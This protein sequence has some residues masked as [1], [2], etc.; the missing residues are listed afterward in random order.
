[1]WVVGCT[2]SV[3]LIALVM[4]MILESSQLEGFVAKTPLKAY[5][6]VITVLSKDQAATRRVLRRMD[7]RNSKPRKE[8]VAS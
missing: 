1:M 7:D 8:E 5:M 2:I 6:D 4:E 3:T